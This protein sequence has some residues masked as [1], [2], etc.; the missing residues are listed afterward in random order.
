[1]RR[2]LTYCLA[3]LMAVVFNANTAF[4][5]TDVP[6]DKR[7]N[8]HINQNFNGL[9]TDF[10]GDKTPAVGTNWRLVSYGQNT[11]SGFFGE[12][13]EAT[14]DLAAGN[15]KLGGSGSGARAA[16][17]HF[18]A[19]QNNPDFDEFSTFIVEFDWTYAA[20]SVRAAGDI[21]HVIGLAGSNSVDRWDPA[22]TNH[23]H[24]G[25]FAFYTF[26]T[27]T[28]YCWNL[29][30]EGNPN[31][32]AA[33]MGAIFTGNNSGGAWVR[34]GSDMEATK[35]MNETCK[36][37]VRAIKG[38]TYHIRAEL[39]FTTQ[40]V[41][42]L[43]ISYTD[44]SGTEEA[45]NWTD[46]DFIA[47]YCAGE[48][49]EDK[50]VKDV[51]MISTSITPRPSGVTNNSDNRFDNLEVYTLVP[52]EGKADVTIKYV[53]QEGAAV[54]PSR[55]EE[56]LYVGIDYSLVPEDKERFQDDLYFY[57]YNPEATYAANNGGESVRVATGGSTLTV[58]FEK[59]AK[60]F[61][62]YVWT[63]E[64]NNIWS[65][66]DANFSVNGGATIPYQEGNPVLFPK[67]KAG[68]VLLKGSFSVGA[69]EVTVAGDYIFSNYDSGIHALLGDSASQFI[70]EEGNVTLGFD[71]KMPE[72]LVFVDSITITKSASAQKIIFK[73]DNSKL[74]HKSSSTL[75]IPIE[76]DSEIVQSALL[77][78]Y[79][80]HLPGLLLCLHYSIVLQYNAGIRDQSH[81]IPKHSLLRQAHL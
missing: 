42:S 74:I 58:V 14:Y 44:E 28:L 18:I 40:K 70:I 37:N 39:D 11:G 7:P 68:E 9:A 36:T 77:Y 63:G 33:G 20:S 61:G 30:P 43:T 5:A 54:K 67:D 24:A 76:Y 71:C 6:D 55:I 3:I 66:T 52:S 46:L 17:M 53:D 75:N 65:E 21:G 34:K 10:W 60:T 56:D 4:A 29:D 73:K 62:T 80:Q 78:R 51:C 45:H 50:T 2:K 49:V 41:V 38:T 1:M 23:F 35:A 72:T 64:T 47:K 16:N 59:T 27:D 79:C 32:E 12:N 57:A 22:S 48:S 26:G 69:S 13:G 31:G 81:H 19:P 25:I 15:V 8:Y